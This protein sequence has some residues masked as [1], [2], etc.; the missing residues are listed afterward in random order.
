MSDLRS[1]THPLISV[2]HTSDNGVAHVRLVYTPLDGRGGWVYNARV[3]APLREFV[4]FD[5]V[6]HMLA[7]V[8]DGE[9]DGTYRGTFAIRESHMPRE[10]DDVWF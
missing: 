9:A 6:G 4:L 3:R 2:S 5:I 1:A 7:G 10:D 8:E